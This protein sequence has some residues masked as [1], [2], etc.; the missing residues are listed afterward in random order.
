M[1]KEGMGSDLSPPHPFSD[2]RKMTHASANRTDPCM[3]R[4]M[5]RSM[6]GIQPSKN[7]GTRR[8]WGSCCIVAGVV[9]LFLMCREVRGTP[10]RE[11][12]Y[13]SCTSTQ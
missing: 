1:E 13:L 11:S 4:C 3:Q 6:T 12:G 8:Q 2:W 7:R 10:I 9:F 5:H